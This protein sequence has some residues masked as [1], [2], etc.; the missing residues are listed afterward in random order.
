MHQGTRIV[1]DEILNAEGGLL[2]YTSLEHIDFLS[3]AHQIGLQAIFSTSATT[4]TLDLVV[5]IQQSGDGRNW[6]DKNTTPEL[7]G[8]IV[9]GPGVGQWSLLGGETWP[10]LPRL[11]FVMLYISMSTRNVSPPASRL[12]LIVTARSRTKAATEHIEPP[13]RLAPVSRREAMGRLLGM[14]PS[15]FDE[16]EMQMR[17]MKPG[18]GPGQLTNRLSLSARADLERV[19]SNL[20]NLGPVQKHA[21]L[22][23]TNALTSLLML[24]P[25]RPETPDSSMAPHTRQA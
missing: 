15:T 18:D 17:A 19:T 7:T 1:F 22:T 13:H 2:L 4:G 23:F 3:D 16:V 12:Q 11:R 10:T 21:A 9:V 25:E 5:R 24:P 20:R 6:L 14:R 8:H